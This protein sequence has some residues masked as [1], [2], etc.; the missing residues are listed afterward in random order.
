MTKAILFFLESEIFSSDNSD[1][2]A[3]VGEGRDLLNIPL[4]IIKSWIF[5][6]PNLTPP[7]TL[8]W[9]IYD[10]LFCPSY[11]S[12]RYSLMQ[13][14]GGIFNNPNLTPPLTLTWTIYDSRQ[15]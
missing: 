4:L 7:L 10:T 2:P 12:V 3:W 14:K 5:N 1:G 11:W 8:N 13:M 15:L 6:N 9:T